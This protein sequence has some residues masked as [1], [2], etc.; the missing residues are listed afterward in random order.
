MAFGKRP[1]PLPGPQTPP[2]APPS[3][4]AA[5]EAPEFPGARQVAPDLIAFGNGEPAD[6]V[7]R[8][9]GYLSDAYRDERGV[10][11]ETILSAA[12]ALA[13]FAAQQALWEGV[14][15]PRKL[16]A[17]QVFMR[18]TTKSGETFFFGD[19]LNRI[20]GLD[21]VRRAV[22]LAPGRRRHRRRRP[23]GACAG[24]VV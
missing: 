12:G 22:D 3:A 8:L 13:G 7:A 20:L 4:P 10:H 23:A 19:F 18:V 14:V 24:A 1:G 5:A 15:R 9:V 6:G 21:A 16:T 17:K 2:P 11:A